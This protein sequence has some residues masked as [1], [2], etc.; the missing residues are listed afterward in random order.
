MK[1]PTFFARRYSGGGRSEFEI[2]GVSGVGIILSNGAEVEL[3]RASSSMFEDFEDECTLSADGL[4]I[5]P[6]AGN[7]V[8][9]SGAGNE[10]RRREFDEDPTQEELTNVLELLSGLDKMAEE[11][12]RLRGTDVAKVVHREWV[13]G[14]IRTATA[15]VRK[16]LR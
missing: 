14:N 1:G 6:Q 2:K 4:S 15:A 5:K 12:V 10:R 11:L 13:R 3:S 7:C 16:V 9:V 8:R